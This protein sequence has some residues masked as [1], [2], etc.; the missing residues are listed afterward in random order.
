MADPQPNDANAAQ[1]EFWNS[2]PAHAWADEHERID[3]L[4]AELTAR[5]LEFA[6]PKPG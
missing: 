4:V 5:L 6:A 1:R 3:R 2:P